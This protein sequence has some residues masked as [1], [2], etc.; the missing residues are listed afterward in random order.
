MISKPKSL[1]HIALPPMFGVH[2]NIFIVKVKVL[3]MAAKPIVFSIEPRMTLFLKCRDREGETQGQ[4][5][6]KLH[7]ASVLV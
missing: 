7:R 6:S 2:T 5:N 3:S 4:K 1:P